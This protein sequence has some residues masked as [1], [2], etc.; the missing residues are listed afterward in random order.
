MFVIAKMHTEI[1][2]TLGIW[3]SDA[4]NQIWYANLVVMHANVGNALYSKSQLCTI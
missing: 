2:F 3:T 4:I 1:V